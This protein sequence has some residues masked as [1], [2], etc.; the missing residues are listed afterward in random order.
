MAL[1]W[2]APK[3]PNDV[4]DYV[5]DWTQRLAGDTLITSEWTIVEGEELVVDSNS[6]TDTHTT[7]WL[8]GGMDATTAYILNRVTTDGGRTYDQTMKLKIKTA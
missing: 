2:S 8:S 7:V 3:D 4:K 6:Y 1:S 5:L